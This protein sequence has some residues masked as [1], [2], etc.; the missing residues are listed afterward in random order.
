M[1]LYFLNLSFFSVAQFESPRSLFCK[2]KQGLLCLPIIGECAELFEMF[3]C[4]MGRLT[5]VQNGSDDIR[6]EE[7]FIDHACYV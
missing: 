5:A 2:A 6:G 7:G 4:E 1:P 3:E